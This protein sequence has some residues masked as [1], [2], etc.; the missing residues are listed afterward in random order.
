VEN[1]RLYTIIDRLNARGSD[2]CSDTASQ[3]SDLSGYGHREVRLALV[4][5]QAM[6]ALF[7]QGD[8]TGPP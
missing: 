3:L 6:Q 5:I 4:P 2:A 7:R 1:Q 8:Y